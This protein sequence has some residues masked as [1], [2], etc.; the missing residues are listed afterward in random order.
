LGKGSTII[1]RFP[2]GVDYTFTC[3]QR[4]EDLVGVVI[5]FARRIHLRRQP[6]D[7]AEATPLMVL[8]LEH[9]AADSIEPL[10]VTLD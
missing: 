4:A 9:E 2:G 10:H 1:P 5:S 6:D 7:L 8:L 3:S